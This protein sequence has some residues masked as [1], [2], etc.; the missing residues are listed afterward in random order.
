MSIRIN[1]YMENKNKSTM[2]DYPFKIEPY[3]HQLQALG[4]SWDQK[5]FAL[6]MEMGTGKT[7]VIIDNIAM[8]Y[9]QGKI[10]GVIIVAPKGV[11]R[12]WERIEIPKHMPSHVRYKLSVWTPPSNRS[13]KSETNLNQMFQ[14]D[15]DLHILLMNV[16]AFSSQKSDGKTGTDFA[17]KFLMSH[18]TMFVVD[19]STTIKSQKAT[20]TANICKVGIHA[21]YKRIM[22]GSP[23][24]KSPLDLYTQCFFL[25]PELL[26]QGSYYAFQNRY[27]IIRKMNGPYGKF[28]KIIGYQN[29]EDLTK[30]LSRFSFRCLK[31][32][33]LDLPNKIYIQRNIELT[34]EQ[35]KAYETMKN[36]NISLLEEGGQ[37]RALNVL[38]QIMKLHQITCGHLKTNEGDIVRLD[39]N[40]V[41]ELLNILDETDGKVIIWAVFR[42]DIQSITEAIRKHFKDE[43][44]AESFYGDTADKDRQD[45]VA[46]FQ[47]P[48]SSLKYFVSNPKTGGYGLTLTAANTVV[49]Y[50]NSYDLEVRLQSEDRA[51]RIGQT[52]HVTYIDMI[53]ED[54]VDDKIVD[55]LKRKIN[56][57]RDVM[58][59]ELKEWLK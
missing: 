29:L 39:N 59:E 13:D 40:R 12:N 48:N 8:L 4:C 26:E 33:C 36:Y 10:D 20:R 52:K 42:E 11:Y 58:G 49:Y 57:A 14:V 9:D 16:E 19:E 55:A 51:H 56:L 22:T 23:V 21:K 37:V 15:D 27:A 2:G 3:K 47:D 1:N 31:E 53:A 28:A 18:K 35:V 25:D 32:D 34:K 24:T 7:K 44:I 54:T 5:N 30:L 50:S 17:R 43:E 45:I 46:K 41:N 6:F 38:S